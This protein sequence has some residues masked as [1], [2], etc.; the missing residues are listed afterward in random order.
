VGPARQPT[1]AIARA[2]SV[3]PDVDDERINDDER[4]R[5][6]FP[7]RY[8]LR[9][10]IQIHLEAAYVVGLL[11]GSMYGLFQTW[12]GG[13]AG[14][15]ISDC[16]SC[17]A[18]DLNQYAYLVFGGVLGGSAF[19]LKYLYK[20]VARG[21]WNEDRRLWR[22]VSPILSGGVAFAAGTLA[23]AGLF[24]F[25]VAEETRGSPFVALG[26]IAGY[27]A[28][29]AVGKMQEIAETVFG[30]HRGSPRPRS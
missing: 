12:S 30:T 18:A 27:F 9:A 4:V 3:P 23:D 13:L 7:S 16:A 5:F 8:P 19:G 10:N 15:L 29:S 1:D 24:G 17:S 20:V 6:N 14:W 11:F 21:W 2:D 25:A 28:D 22:L 26:F